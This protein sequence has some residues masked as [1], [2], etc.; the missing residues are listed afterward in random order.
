MYFWKSILRMMVG[1]ILPVIAGIF[2]VRTWDFGRPIPF[3]IGVPSYTVVYC[4]S[5]WL[6]GLNKAEKNTIVSAFYKKLGWNK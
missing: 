6:F 2:M 5:M 4:V 3:L 1:L